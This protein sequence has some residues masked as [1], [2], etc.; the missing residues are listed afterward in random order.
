MFPRKLA[1]VSASL[2]LIAVPVVA[3]AATS[4]P[5]AGPGTVYNAA[6]YGATPNTGQD[7]TAQLQAALTAATQDGG[8]QVYIGPG[9]YDERGLTMGSNVT[10]EGV[11][12]GSTGTV[13]QL[14]SNAYAITVTAGGSAQAVGAT[15]ENLR[16]EASGN[17]NSAGGGIDL[18]YAAAALVDHVT[19]NAAH[20]AGIVLGPNAAGNADTFNSTISN[21]NVSGSTVGISLGNAEENVITADDLEYDTTAVTEGGVGNNSIT[22]DTFVAGGDAIVSNGSNGRWVSNKFDG[23]GGSDFVISGS[24]N[25]IADS[26][27][28]PLGSASS[29][30]TA[31]F[32][33][34]EDGA[35]GNNIQ[36][37]EVTT[38]GTNGAARS[39]VRE[40]SAN[41]SDNLIEDNVVRISGSFSAGTFEKHSSSDQYANDHIFTHR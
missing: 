5:P 35:Y 10:L 7:E 41:N 36:A 12:L 14:T 28:G 8:G 34:L 2:A 3:I 37:N 13:L 27:V 9:T 19:I 21:S 20:T 40:V 6:T 31:S 29:P 32:V 22:D 11:G 26:D 39:F 25:T 4:G 38:N 17:G 16:I 1:A 23:V 30:G 15:I 24:S 18:V 33:V